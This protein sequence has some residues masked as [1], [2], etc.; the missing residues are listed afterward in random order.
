MEE[1]K[2][3]TE[4]SRFTAKQAK[5]LAENEMSQIYL[6]IKET[7]SKGL[8]NMSLSFDTKEKASKVITVLKSDGYTCKYLRSW[9]DSLMMYHEMWNISW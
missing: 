7:S 6:R 1:T 9:R 3:S 4:L 2:K 8:R 5:E